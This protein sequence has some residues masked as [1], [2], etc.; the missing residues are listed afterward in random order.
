MANPLLPNRLARYGI[1]Q[2][3]RGRDSGTKSSS[4]ASGG[5]PLGLLGPIWWPRRGWGRS[6]FPR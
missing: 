1:R 2:R 5:D 3:L 6:W 4:P